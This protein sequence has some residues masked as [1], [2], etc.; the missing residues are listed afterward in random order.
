MVIDV[1]SQTI[2][3]G[4]RLKALAQKET[5]WIETLKATQFPGLNEDIDYPVFL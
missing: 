1:I 5:Y 3:G 4:N 2:R